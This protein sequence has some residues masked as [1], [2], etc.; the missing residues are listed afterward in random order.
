MLVSS[1]LIYD[2]IY[3]AFESWTGSQDLNDDE[4]GR[5]LTGVWSPSIKI[6]TKYT[7]WFDLMI[8]ISVGLASWR[9]TIILTRYLGLRY[10]E[11]SD[12]TA[13]VFTTTW[14]ATVSRRTELHGVAPT[15]LIQFAK[16]EACLPDYIIW[17]NQREQFFTYSYILVKCDKWKQ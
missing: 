10:D 8:L 4:M 11:I 17:T 13:L 12:F 14:L 6:D 16:S 1:C 5:N 9:M 3:L 7:K 15:V 2:S